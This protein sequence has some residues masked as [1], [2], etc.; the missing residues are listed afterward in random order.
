MKEMQC[1]C[2]EK[3]AW[4]RTQVTGPGK[5]NRYETGVEGK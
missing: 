3:A 4:R 2:G 1:R 5:L